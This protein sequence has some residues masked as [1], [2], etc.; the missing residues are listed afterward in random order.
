MRE[1]NILDFISANFIA[2]EWLVRDRSSEIFVQLLP[3]RAWYFSSFL[4]CFLE[5]LQRG[6][7]WQSPVEMENVSVSRTGEK[8]FCVRW[9][10]FKMKSPG[11]IRLFTKLLEGTTVSKWLQSAAAYTWAVSAVAPIL[12]NGLPR[13]DREPPPRPH[14]S[15]EWEKQNC[16]GGHF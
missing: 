15:S 11:L 7:W 2:T 12:W 5:Y 3:Y 1:N 6:E 9:Q 10:T 13:E 4:F 16:S 14:H 8:S